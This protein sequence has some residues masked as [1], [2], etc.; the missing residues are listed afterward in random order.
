VEDGDHS[1]RSSGKI[2][3]KNVMMGM[4]YEGNSGGI[5]PGMLSP[6][7]PLRRGFLDGRDQIARVF[8]RLILS[9]SRGRVLPNFQQAIAGRRENF[10]RHF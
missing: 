10:N 5:K 2:A 8:V 9:P 3:E 1:K 6:K 4:P 7:T